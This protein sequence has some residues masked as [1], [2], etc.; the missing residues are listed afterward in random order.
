M[1]NKKLGMYIGII[2]FILI[3]LGIGYIIYINVNNDEGAVLDGYTP[4]AEVTEEQLRKT[5]VTLYFMDVAT[6]ELMPEPR[7]I[8][9][10]EL[11]E[12]PYYFLIKLLIEGP[13][14][15]IMARILPLNTTLN[16]AKLIGNIVYLDFSEGLIKDQNLG[17]KQE[18]LIIKAIVNTLTELIEVEGVRITIDGQENLGFPDG[19]VVF[20]ETFTRQN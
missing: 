15:E 20:T 7:Q 10:R 8:D 6:E 9:I 18:M 4:Q 19:Q 1:K 16:E 17:E 3:I 12:N 5:I 13:K 11:I 14:N 2:L